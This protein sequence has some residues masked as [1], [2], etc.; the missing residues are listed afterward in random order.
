MLEL[1][2][3]AYCTFYKRCPACGKTTFYSYEEDKGIGDPRVKSDS[4]MMPDPD[5]EEA[6]DKNEESGDQELAKEE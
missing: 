4:D 5:T 2:D 1:K 6:G 3:L